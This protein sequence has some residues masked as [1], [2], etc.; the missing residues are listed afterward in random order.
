MR[1]PGYNVPILV[2]C[3][4]RVL[5]A[6]GRL[7]YLWEVWRN[8]A[9]NAG[10][11]KPARPTIKGGFHPHPTIELFLT[12]KYRNMRSPTATEW[13]NRVF[14]KV[15][16]DAS[17]AHHGV[18][19]ARS[20]RAHRARSINPSASWSGNRKRQ[21]PS[22]RWSYGDHHAIFMGKSTKNR[23]GH[24]NN[25]HVSLPEGNVSYIYIIYILSI[26]IY[27]IYIYNHI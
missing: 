16:N 10:K 1:M 26:Y 18:T 5:H 4:H 11:N 3:R 7:G 9:K 8:F 27:M 24:L 20:L 13:F 22:F 6:Q 12:D 23:L 21:E 19:G 2:S 15:L 17:L 25:S 14:C